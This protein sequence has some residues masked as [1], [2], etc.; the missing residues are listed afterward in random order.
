MEKLSNFLKVTQVVETEFIPSNL[1]LQ[2]II[3]VKNNVCE[4]A[5]TLV[6]G[7]ANAEYS[8]FTNIHNI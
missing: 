4:C 2:L 1:A 8:Y 6:K 5:L 3:C 7:Y